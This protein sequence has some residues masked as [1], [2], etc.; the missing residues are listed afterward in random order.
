MSYTLISSL[1]GVI[2]ALL[3]G[4][5]FG[6]V[7]LEDVDVELLAPCVR[8]FYRTHNYGSIQ[9]TENVLKSDTQ[10]SC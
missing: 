10:K 8:R 6:W 7:S 9:L 5:L 1:V 3:A 2:C 4:F